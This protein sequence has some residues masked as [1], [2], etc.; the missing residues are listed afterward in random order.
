MLTETSQPDFKKKSRI[1]FTSIKSND[2][3]HIKHVTSTSNVIEKDEGAMKQSIAPWWSRV[4]EKWRLNNRDNTTKAQSEVI[5][6]FCIVHSD[7][8]LRVVILSILR[9]N[10]SYGCVTCTFYP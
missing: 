7:R 9:F 4:F 8:F 1:E 5:N 10:S 2:N 3:T 6:L